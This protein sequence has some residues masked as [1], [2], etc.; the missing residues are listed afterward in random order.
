METGEVSFWSKILLF[1]CSVWMYRHV[2]VDSHGED[3]TGS[4][5]LHVTSDQRTEHVMMSQVT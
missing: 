4:N 2:G 1:K 3:E 5:T